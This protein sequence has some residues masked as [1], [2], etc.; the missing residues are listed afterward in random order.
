M[1][2]TARRP[3]QRTANAPVCIVQPVP[4][5][6]DTTDAELVRRAQAG[7]VWAE[8]LLYRR[9]AEFVTGVCTRL[10]RHT[11]DAE[12]TVQ[13]AFVD[14]FEQLG[15]LREPERF[16]GWLTRIAVH[17]AHRRLRRRR[18]HR[19][20][21]LRV[22]TSEEVLGWYACQSVS[23]ELRA[24]LGQLEQ[25]LG[26]L[27]DADRVAWQLRHVEGYQLE[28]VADLCRCSLTT[29]KRRITRADAAVR[30]QVSLEEVEHE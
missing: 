10:L 11:A 17:K 29:A 26:Y 15:A 27:P 13:D 28:E 8:E 22:S 30:R 20:L 16:R 5:G 3:H 24:E 1:T 25:V 6:R 4:V 12:D 19:W 14:A 9:H 21:G 7:D 18:L 2:I 23:P